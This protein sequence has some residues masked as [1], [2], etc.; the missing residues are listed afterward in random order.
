MPQKSAP[1]KPDRSSRTSA[2]IN[3]KPS[4]SHEP[5]ASVQ[6][7]ETEDPRQIGSSKPI[8][9]EMLERNVSG[10]GAARERPETVAGQHATGSFTRKKQGAA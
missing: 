2:K 9:R 5:P 8:Q 4:V 10:D 3:P 7:V 6:T 1:K